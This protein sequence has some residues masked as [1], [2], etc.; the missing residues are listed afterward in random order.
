MLWRRS[1]NNGEAF[2]TVHVG[3]RTTFLRE[4]Y[5]PWFQQALTLMGFALGTALL[6]AFLL[7][8]LALR[9]LEEISLQLDYWT[10]ADQADQR[11]QNAQAGHGGPRLQQNRA[12]RPAHAQCGGGLFRIEGESRSDSRQPAGRH[13][14]LHR[15][16]ARGA[17][18]RGGAA[19]PQ[20]G[21]RQPA[22]PARARRSST[23]RR[24]WAGPC[25][26]PSMPE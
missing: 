18:L 8:N 23:A 3:V 24:C 22:G 11:R 1:N 12:D 9:P 7:G 6:V 20:R 14:A 13:S 5:E 21:A 17:G 26:R 16:W 4:V 2:A 25:A 15:G 19:L 10:A